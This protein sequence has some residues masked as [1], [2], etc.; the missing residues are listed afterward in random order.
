MKGVIFDYDGTLH[1]SIRIY[2]PA[3]H[4]AYEYLVEKGHAPQRVERLRDR[5]V[6][7][8]QQQGYVE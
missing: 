3:F 5:K 8:I 2:A 1:E 7:G 4:R 6:A